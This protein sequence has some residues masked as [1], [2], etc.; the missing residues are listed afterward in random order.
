MWEGQE[1]KKEGGGRLGRGGRMDGMGGETSTCST[2]APWGGTRDGE[3]RE[4]V[5][6]PPPPPPK[7]PT[8]PPKPFHMHA[9]TVLIAHTGLKG[10]GDMML[11]SSCQHIC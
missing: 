8:P 2:D 7:P 9:H 4:E 1:R 3:R 5:N 11:M 10:T 6:S